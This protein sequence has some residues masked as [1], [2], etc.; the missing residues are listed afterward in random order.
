MFD[1]SDTLMDFIPPLIVVLIFIG[2]LTEGDFKLLHLRTW[3]AKTSWED[4]LRLL[5]CIESDASHPLS[6]AMIAAAKSE[7]VSV[8]KSWKMENHTNLEGEGVTAVIDAR[9]VHVGNCR[10][11]KR[12]SY[13]ED[14][15][16][17][18]LQLA[19]GWM[20][21]GGTV[22]F[23]SID[24]CGIVASYCVTDA[25]R[26]EAKDVIASFHK[27]GIDT[28][29]LT[30]DNTKAATSIGQGLGL[31]EKQIRSQL[32]PHEKLEIV[33]ELIEEKKVD[34]AKSSC[35]QRRRH[36]LVLMCG[37]GV[38][39]APALAIAHVGVAM[40]AGAALAME[41]A[42]V[43]LLDS[44]LTKL[45]KVVKLGRRVNR[46]ILEN[47]VFSFVAKAVV[48][49]FAFAG[50]SSLWAAIGSD[51]GAMLLVTANGMKLLPSKKSVRSGTGFDSYKVKGDHA[52]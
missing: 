31:T 32:L 6:L 42:D 22:G 18:E 47:V 51:V 9:I 28:I 50:Y 48:M 43:T 30:G 23:V 27:L 2:T 3:D 40:G 14:M 16:D 36:G 1:E 8:P 52:A 15:P 39:D 24:G 34:S 45:L 44:N 19:M 12:L 26:D 29:M 4:V 11:F 20:G 35:L 33:K 46:T 38:N 10:L 17:E 37:D 25:V 13:L 7:N 21:N 49:G 41:T 5:R